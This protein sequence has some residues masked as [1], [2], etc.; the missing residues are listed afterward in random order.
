MIGRSTSPVGAKRHRPALALLSAGVLWGTSGTAQP[1]GVALAAV[2]GVC[3]GVYTVSAKRLLLA[4]HDTLAV[5]AASLAVGAAVLAPV[6]IT[7]SR[8]LLDWRGAALVAWLGIAT[9]ALAY[10]LFARGLGS[11]AAA[12]AGMLSLAE[13]L[14]ATI[15]GLLVLDE[16]AAPIAAAGAALLLIGL[17]IAAVGARTITGAPIAPAIRTAGPA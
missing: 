1:T 16:W 17:F 12:T 3:Y 6:L 10:P 14:T 11:V 13:P 8:L 9:T 7:H 2:A 4:Q 5:L 15:L